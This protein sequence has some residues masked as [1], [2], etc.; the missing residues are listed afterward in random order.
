MSMEVCLYFHCLFM[1]VHHVQLLP[2]WGCNESNISPVIHVMYHVVSSGQHPISYEQHMGIACTPHGY[3]KHTI[4]VSHAHHHQVQFMKIHHVRPL[5]EV[6]VLFLTFSY[7]YPF[8]LLVSVFVLLSEL[9]R[10]LLW[11][12]VLEEDCLHYLDPAKII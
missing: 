5:H 12:L 4:W 11:T 10:F 1:K 7:F 3:H 8:L 6:A 2:L 9:L